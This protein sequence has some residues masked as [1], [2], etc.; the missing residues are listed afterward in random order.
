M[1]GSSV[2]TECCSGIRSRTTF[3][4]LNPLVNC[5]CDRQVPNAANSRRKG[6]KVICS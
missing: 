4:R 5:G 3:L 1:P 2:T 6:G